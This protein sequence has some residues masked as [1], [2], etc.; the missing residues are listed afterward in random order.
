MSSEPN[1]VD[2]AAL[3][4]ILNGDE[5]PWAALDALAALLPQAEFAA[6]C[7]HTLD[8]RPVG[9]LS[10]CLVEALD[11]LPGAQGGDAV[12]RLLGRLSPE[13]HHPYPG[14]AALSYLLRRGRAREQAQAALS[15]FGRVKVVSGYVGNP[16]LAELAQLAIAYAPAQARELVRRALR[17]GG[18]TTKAKISAT[19]AVLARLGQ[20]WQPWCHEELAAALA[21]TTERSEG[22][23][24][25]QALSYTDTG[26]GTASACELAQ[27]WLRAHPPA[28]HVGPGY[29][30]E[31]V[32][33]ANGDDWFESELEK[34]KA[35]VQNLQRIGQI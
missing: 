16:F 3:L 7:A 4:A 19:L 28:A 20:P 11:K 14:W 35:W 18:P 12:E 13:Q 9:T 17:E 26:T 34:A 22:L 23:S 33:E 29:T 1:K 5:K 21:D 25:C 8:E 15:A 24:L 31:E 32:L 10:A 30:W 2:A 6:L 27:S